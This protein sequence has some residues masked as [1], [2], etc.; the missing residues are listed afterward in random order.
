MVLDTQGSEL[1]V[2][3]GAGDL[4]NGFKFIKLEVPDFEAYKDCPQVDD[5]D[6][7]L[8]P[9]GFRERNRNRFAIRDAG[10]SYYDIV[11][12]KSANP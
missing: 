2:L 1:L 3:K 4:L 8:R 9:Y 5:I 11:Y 10:G 7:F 12:E 6:E